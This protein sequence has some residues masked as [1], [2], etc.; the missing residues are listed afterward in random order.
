MKSIKF[1]NMLS[2]ASTNIVE[3]VEATKSNLH[4]LLGSEQ[5]E[6]LS[7]PAFGLKVKSYFFEQNNDILTDIIIDDIYE[8]I[9]LFMPQLIINRKDIT[10]VKSM[11]RLTANVKVTNRED[12]TTDLY[13]LV[14]F[15]NTIN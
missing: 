3:G 6:F 14:L 13:S 5:G 10:L 7:D 1:P 8:Q 15:D 2:S 11:A 4:T 9:S 12:F